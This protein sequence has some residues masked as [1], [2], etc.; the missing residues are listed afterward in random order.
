MRPRR[1]REGMK[2]KRGRKRVNPK[3][4][5]LCVQAEDRCRPEHFP[6]L[7]RQLAGELR[8]QPTLTLVFEA[9]ARDYRYW[10][11]EVH[12]SALTNL[13]R[14]R[15]SLR[16]L[17]VEESPASVIAKAAAEARADGIGAKKKMKKNER[18]KKQ[19][20]GKG[21][22]GK[23]AGGDAGPHPR[24]DHRG[25]YI[26]ASDGRELCYKFNNVKCREPC[27]NKR[28]LFCQICLKK[29]AARHCIPAAA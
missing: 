29:H 19:Q 20:P 9:D 23:G 22:G 3:A 12:R 5:H 6:P 14:P 10:D 28:A 21:A 25:R 15:N 16:E 1:I 17:S 18:N 26:T 2:T 24:T 27:P 4:W 7:W 13:V 8:Q 11:R